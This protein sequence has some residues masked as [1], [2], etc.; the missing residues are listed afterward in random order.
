MSLAVWA[1][2]SV[3][4]TKQLAVKGCGAYGKSNRGHLGYAKKLRAHGKS[5]WMVGPLAS[6]L[7]LTHNDN[8][9]DD[10]SALQPT[11]PPLAPPL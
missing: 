3:A 11:L 9:D 2:A 10:E 8:D 6:P 7:G 5:Q 4:K 1:V